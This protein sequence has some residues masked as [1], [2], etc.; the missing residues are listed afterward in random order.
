MSKPVKRVKP[1]KVTAVEEPTHNGE[2][3]SAER[4]AFLRANELEK[5]NLDKEIAILER[6]LGIRANA[7]KRRKL[8]QVVEEEG[9]G[10]GF[11][12]FIDGIE[13]KVKTQAVEGYR[14]QEYVFSDG[15]GVEE[16]DL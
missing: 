4:A 1:E 8:N 5:A 10:R 11:M 13:T 12:D 16:G 3:I 2:I 7:R 9:F 6:R 15:E 14:P